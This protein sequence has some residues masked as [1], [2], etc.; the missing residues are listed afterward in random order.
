MSALNAV[1][2]S[3]QVARSAGGDEKLLD[4]LLAQCDDMECSECGRIICPFDDLLHFHH[5]GCPS[6]SSH[7]EAVDDF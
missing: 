1:H 7:D 3:L 5:D 2:L 6:C 4:T